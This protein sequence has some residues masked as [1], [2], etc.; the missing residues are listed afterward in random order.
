MRGDDVKALQQDLIDAGY[1]V[2][3]DGADGKFGTNTFRAVV[4]FQEDFGLPATGIADPDTIKALSDVPDQN[5]DFWL[6][7]LA[8]GS[9]GDAVVLLQAALTIRGFACGS[10]DGI[11][12][13]KT[14][15]AVNRFAGSRGLDQSGTVKAE[16]WKL[17]LGVS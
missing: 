17:L 13:A 9:K 1:N 8:M 5:A 14:Q 16:F 12:G 6:P 11:F 2:G 15:A 10:Q 3:P 7:D 4:A